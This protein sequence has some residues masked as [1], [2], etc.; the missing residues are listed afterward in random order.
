[1]G[2]W[3]WRRGLC[4]ASFGLCHHISR[5][6][7]RRRTLVQMQI[8]ERTTPS[9]PI[10][11]STEGYHATSDSLEMRACVPACLRACVR[12]QVQLC[13]EA[14]TGGRR[15]RK[16]AENRAEG[17]RCPGKHC[18]LY[19]YGLRVRISAADAG[20]ESR[21]KGWIAV[22][23]SVVAQDQ[24]SIKTHLDSRLEGCRQLR[25]A[26]SPTRHHPLAHAPATVRA[27][28]LLHTTAASM[29]ARHRR[30]RLT[31]LRAP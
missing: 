9:G 12:L 29:H 6:S 26:A 23:W 10:V 18:R 16:R 17:E 2:R 1:M 4:H 19:G 22:Q 30:A 8:F 14:H 25:L 15:K 31:A 21:I 13:L 20:E 27:S 7:W 24:D 3:K 5:E 11:R 28:L